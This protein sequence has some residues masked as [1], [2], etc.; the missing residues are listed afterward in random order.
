MEYRYSPPSPTSLS[1]SPHQVAVPFT[2]K[3]LIKIE[4][5]GGNASLFSLIKPFRNNKNNNNNNLNTPFYQGTLDLTCTSR[6]TTRSFEELVIEL[7]LGE[8][9]TSM[10]A[11]ASSNALWVFDPRTL[12]LRWEMKNVPPSGTYTLHGTWSSR[13]CF[14][15]LSRP[16]SSLD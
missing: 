8:G 10:N 13:Y 7:H 5:N 12:T 3:A 4:E 16:S 2:L 11:S 1:A 14:S 9:A 15:L 6:L